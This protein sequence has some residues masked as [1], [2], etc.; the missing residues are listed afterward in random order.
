MGRLSVFIP[1]VALASLTAACPT[2]TVNNITNVAAPEDP[3]PDDDTP[4]PAEV[5]C[6]PRLQPGTADLTGSTAWSMDELKT[7]STLG[8]PALLRTVANSPSRLTRA[9]STIAVSLETAF[10]IE[11][12]AGYC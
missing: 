7:T 11:K 12:M 10:S 2:P 4:P 1:I 9:T 8:A 6:E 5:V 3:P